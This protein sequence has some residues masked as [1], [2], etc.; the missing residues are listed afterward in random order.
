M[1][2]A[3]AEKQMN[4]G[5]QAPGEHEDVE[6]LLKA[7]IVIVD[8]EPT[9]MEVVQAFLEE[10]GYHNFALIENSSE[11]LEILE[12][13]QPDLL[14]LDLIM[15]RVSGFELLKAVRKNPKLR[16]LPV[17]ILTSSSDN[18]DKLS[19][20]D[21][22]ATDF[23]AKPVDP[24]ELRLRVRNT[25]AAKAYTDH[26]AFYD[27][28]TKLPNRHLFMEC[29][30][31]GLASARRNH[32]KLALLSIEL[33]QFDKVSDTLGILA[34]DEIL[35]QLTKRFKEVIKGIDIL[36]YFDIDEYAPANLFHIDGGVFA[37]LLQRIPN[38]RDAAM[39]SDCLL[40]S[41]R[42]M[43]KVENTEIYLTASI[44]IAT[45]PTE[46][47]DALS[48]LQQASIAKDF[49]KNSGGDA[50]Q[51]SS[52]RI[53]KQYQKRLNL[54]ARLRKALQRNEFMLY[55][56]PQLDIHTNRIMGVEALLRW[57]VNQTTMIPPDK[58]IPLAEETRLIIPIGEWV[59]RQAC[60]QLAAWQRAGA[61]PIRMSVNL[62]PVQF[63][64]RQMPAIFKRIIENSGISPQWL[65]LEV[66][67]GMF[68]DNVEQKID[69]MNRLKALGV[70][71]SI[72]DF[73]TGYS[74]LN[75]LKRLPLDELKIDR[76][77]FRD[78]FGD[79]KSR[80]LVATLIY[81]SRSLKLLTIAEGVETE[82]QLRYL[83]EGACDQYQGFLFSPPVPPEQVL[84]M[85]APQ[86]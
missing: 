45:Y 42:W 68:L 86:A 65:T 38:E 28:L 33:D 29:L 5:Y 16:R 23:L 15:P 50:F 37:L 43:L 46:D 17:I 59:L 72:D 31:K 9:T 80:A 71:L 18:Q 62:S 49:V 54:E 75:Y 35:R 56:Q 26:L 19:A 41:I 40:D 25:L 61:A 64:S 13:Q 51:F 70:K 76:S 53:N 44:G 73:G 30:E 24:S 83:R 47:G 14:L 10:A 4:H 48:L 67:E 11:A 63:E 66:T 6:Q 2:S 58:F 22:G 1:Q 36:G 78:L 20:L 8:D 85:L 34:G 57:Q 74:C 3:L 77:F 79:T 21:L 12:Q 39:I 7:S 52:R 32:E 82:D 81:L 84:T 27:P 55:Y 60:R 69:A